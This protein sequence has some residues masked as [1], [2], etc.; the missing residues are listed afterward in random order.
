MI[1]SHCL[2]QRKDSNLHALRHTHL[3]RARLP[4]RHLG[5][6]L[7]ATAKVVIIFEIA[8]ISLQKIFFG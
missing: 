7:N 5:I 2:C 1:N 3:K 6:A 8:T 4:F